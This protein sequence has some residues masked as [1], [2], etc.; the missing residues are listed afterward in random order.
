MGSQENFG[1]ALLCF[2]VVLWKSGQAKAEHR[3][4]VTD[5]HQS[6]LAW[7]AWGRKAVGVGWGWQWAPWALVT[8]SQMGGGGRV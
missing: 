7:L 6:I 4:L 5:D 2:I 8:S 1:S 3:T